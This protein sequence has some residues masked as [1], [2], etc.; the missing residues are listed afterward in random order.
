M[1]YVSQIEI[2]REREGG[3]ARE[4]SHMRE[5][6]RKERYKEIQREREREIF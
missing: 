3:E 1:S 5:K 4:W 6:E 2:W